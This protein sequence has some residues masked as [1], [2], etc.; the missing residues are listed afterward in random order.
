MDEP[1]NDRDFERFLADAYQAPSDRPEAP[2][3]IAAVLV[4]ARRRGRVRVLVLASATAVGLGIAG[5]AFAVSGVGRLLAEDLTDAS[6]APAM[7]DPSLVVAAGLVL[8]IA[9]AARN[10]LRER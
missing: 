1:M 3:L 8:M 4:R 10:A 6:S 7:I 2:Q 9:A 5:A